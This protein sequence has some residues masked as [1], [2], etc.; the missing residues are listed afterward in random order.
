LHSFDAFFGGS[1]I[2]SDGAQPFAGLVLSSNVLYGG[3]YIGGPTGLGTLFNVT[4][5]GLNYSP[6]YALTNIGAGGSEG[7]LV[8]SSNVLYGTTIFGG[9]VGAGNIFRM[10][11]GTG[12]TTLHEFTAGSDGSSPFAGLLLSSNVPYGTTQY[13]ASGQGT[14]F[15]INIDGTAFTILHTFTNNEGSPQG[16]SLAMLGNTLFGMNS[17]GQHIGV[18]YSLNTDGTCFTILHDF[19]VGTDQPFGGLT[20]LGKALY[21]TTYG[22]G[23]AGFGTIFRFSLLPQ[24]SITPSEQNVILAWPTSYAGVDYSG[25]RLQSITNLSS[26]V[27]NSV[28]QVPVVINGINF[29]TNSASGAQQFFRLSD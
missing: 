24:L 12:L 13:G 26:G 3:T 11:A 4:T 27:W 20:V 29:V 25:F 21:G 28:P 19:P 14:V 18:I 17:S 1:R 15:K 6:F 22:G 2:N 16:G 23:T 5:D 9:K 7:T 10:N 8:L